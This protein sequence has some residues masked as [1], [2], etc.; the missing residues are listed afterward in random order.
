M[1][2][3]NANTPNNKAPTTP[4]LLT[5]SPLLGRFFFVAFRFFKPVLPLFPKFPPLPVPS[6]GSAGS[7]KL[8]GS[9]WLPS[10]SF[11]IANSNSFGSENPIGISIM[12]RPVQHK[13]SYKRL[14]KPSKV[15]FSSL[16]FEGHYR[17][18][19]SDRLFYTLS[20]IL[21]SIIGS[22][23]FLFQKSIRG[24]V[25]KALI[26]VPIPTGPPKIKASI[27]K[28]ISCITLTTR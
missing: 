24:P 5:I 7:L 9:L 26:I 27:T 21:F 2:V 22:L 28:I 6:P 19:V 23:T 14:K 10:L 8:A 3:K 4:Q 11:A 1:K 13:E 18:K 25:K 20:V 17:I 12:K 15:R 16:T